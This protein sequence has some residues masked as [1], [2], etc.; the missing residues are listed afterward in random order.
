VIY[1]VQITMLAFLGAS[2]LG[3]HTQQPFPGK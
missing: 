1:I 2:H 3:H